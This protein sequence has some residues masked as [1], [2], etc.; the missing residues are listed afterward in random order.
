MFPDRLKELRLQKKLTQKELAFSLS[1]QNTAISKYELGEREPDFKTLERIADF[2]D[3][4]IDYLLGRTDIWASEIIN[5]SNSDIDDIVDATFTPEYDADIP[6]ATYLNFNEHLPI[7]RDYLSLSSENQ[8]EV[9]KIIELYKM[10][11]RQQNNLYYK[12]K[13]IMGYKDK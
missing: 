8:D 1:V 7:L 5:N 10:K 2:F 3:V 6:T 12:N 9:K 13:N 4:S 11:E